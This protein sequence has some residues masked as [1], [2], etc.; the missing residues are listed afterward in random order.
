MKNISTLIKSHTNKLT[1]LVY[2][3]THEI[4]ESKIVTM[5]SLWFI[6][7][8][9]MANLKCSISLCWWRWQKRYCQRHLLACSIVNEAV[10]PSATRKG[11]WCMQE[12]NAAHC[13]TE[14]EDFLVEKFR[15]RK[16]SWY[17]MACAVADLNLLDFYFKTL[18]QR[19]VY[20]EEPCTIPTAVAFCTVLAH[21]IPHARLVLQGV[22]SKYWKVS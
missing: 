9:S 3:K 8:F 7:P 1:A 19:R 13:T 6:L 21:I 18:A 4:V 10:R 14:A 15:S 22:S 16:I 20:V 2:W 17:R 11:H 5:N 12:G